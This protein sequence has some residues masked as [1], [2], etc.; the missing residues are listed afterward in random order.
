MS[1]ATKIS[2]VA[3]ASTISA[4][5]VWA[6]DVRDDL[7]NYITAHEN[8]HSALAQLICEQAQHHKYIFL[9]DTNHGSTAIRD[10][11]FSPQVMQA[12]KDCTASGVLVLEGPPEDK[13]DE[14]YIIQK[15]DDLVRR[16]EEDRK[17]LEEIRTRL[18]DETLSERLR[19]LDQM[20]FD[21]VQLRLMLTQNKARR[22][23]EDF[24]AVFMRDHFDVESAYYDPGYDLSADE[25]NTLR[26]LYR[27]YN[28]DTQCTNIFTVF[29][30]Q[31]FADNPDQFFTNLD[32]LLISRL[33]TVDSQIAQS[34]VNNHPDGA[35][36][37]YGSS[38]MSSSHDL[39]E[40]VG[41]HDSVTINVIGDGNEE[42]YVN[43]GF[44]DLVPQLYG[45][46]F[47]TDDSPEFE[48][49]SILQTVQLGQ[50]QEEPTKFMP[51]EQFENCRAAMPLDVQSAF[52]DALGIDFTFKDFTQMMDPN[53][54]L[55][56]I[57]ENWAPPIL[58]TQ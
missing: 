22:Y 48:Y 16:I 13:Q 33:N 3:V 58:D 30:A 24:R 44:Q 39:D 10:A 29:N 26:I 12:I 32:N 46:T 8:D 6:D 28:D 42:K 34:I 18:D 36:I 50:A 35:V 40:M 5:A 27:S 23:N 49:S 45:R 31:A 9:G 15:Y 55:P 57:I 21:S 4:S 20:I 54:P 38:H 1:I 11:V 56:E 2:S 7:Q 25:L 51:R 17:E 14:A 19:E 47:I 41:A 37:L 53:Q 43:Q 52:I